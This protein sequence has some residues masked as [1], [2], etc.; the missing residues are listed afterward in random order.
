MDFFFD[1]GLIVVDF[2]ENAGKIPI[3]VFRAAGNGADYSG[4]L[5][6]AHPAPGKVFRTAEHPGTG[7]FQHQ[8]H[9]SQY[10][11]AGPEKFVGE[12]GFTPLDEGTRHDC[13]YGQAAF[14]Q[15][16][17]EVGVS[18]GER[19]ELRHTADCLHDCLL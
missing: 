13:Y 10:G 4:G 18:V 5:Q 1:G 3:T 16:F 14:F 17:Y 2:G 12:G 6:D 7:K 8:V 19:V 9:T 11:G 15:F